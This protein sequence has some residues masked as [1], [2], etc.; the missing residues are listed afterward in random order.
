[1]TSLPSNAV[2]SAM[3]G[4]IQ[5]DPEA[6]VEERL[7]LAKTPLERAGT[8]YN[9]QVTMGEMS[10]RSHEIIW[11][12]Q[13][14]IEEEE[15]WKILGLSREQMWEDIRYEEVVGPAVNLHLQSTARKAKF[16][17]QIEKSWGP[18]WRSQFDPENCLLPSQQ[19]EHFVAALRR[20][21]MLPTASPEAA[22]VTLQAVI[23][24]R[25]AA[26]RP[27]TR[28]GASGTA[29]DLRTAYKELSSQLTV[30]EGKATAKRSIE[31]NSAPNKRIRIDVNG[32]EFSEDGLEDGDREVANREDA[33][34]EDAD[35]EDADREDDDKE[36]GDNENDQ[37][38]EAES[39]FEQ[40]IEELKDDLDKDG[41]RCTVSKNLKTKLFSGRGRLE[42]KEVISLIETMTPQV[43]SDLCWFHFRQICT[44]LG[45]KSKTGGKEQLSKRFEV[46][47]RHRFEL[48]NFMT[49][50]QHS[51]WF[52]K[53]HRGDIPS[54]YLGSLRYKPLPP[55]E[56]DYDACDVLERFA[57]AGAA[58]HWEKDGTMIVVGAMGYLWEDAD[59]V[60]LIKEEV[61]M[62]LHH[63][64]RVNGAGNLGWLRSAYHAQIQQIA[65]QDPL[66][67]AL[68]A[69][70]SPKK[71]WKQISFP[72]YM[73][74]V[75]PGDST[76]FQHLDLNLPRYV[77]CER[78]RNRIQTSLTLSPETEQNCTMVVPGFHN[79]IKDW[80]RDVEA[81]GQGLT[82]SGKPHKGNC[83]KTNEIYSKADEQK[84]GKLVP[85]VCGPGDIRVSRPEILHGSTAN[86][87][88]YAESQRW[89]VNPWFVGI[90]DDHETL[91]VPES[92]TWASIA[93]THRDLLA[94]NG[95]P[96]GQTNIHGRPMERFPASVA[97]RNISALSDA[98]IGLRR[99]DD[100]QV[101]ADRDILLGSDDRA[102]WRFVQDC[103]VRL[104]A[105][106]KENMV[107]VR[108][109]E[110]QA[111]GEHSFYNLV[112]S[113]KYKE[114]TYE[115]GE[116]DRMVEDTMD[117]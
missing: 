64:R 81:R 88:G 22:R 62:Y 105:A 97:L 16:Y 7:G 40:R 89:V 24:G 103:R 110:R 82:K 11:R 70:T 102:S 10:Q 58:D 87:D 95:T 69:A 19:S 37:D 28:A 51:G 109:L 36:D 29:G 91:D 48:G 25:M 96:S 66:Y 46:V 18:G 85:C 35:R 20:I 83:T 61:L 79:V 50:T 114:P 53:S 52:R 30:G 15:V 38:Y 60:K 13:K 31:Q 116:D 67:Y 45:I 106:Y 26:R 111:Y 100:P 112:D 57:G 39:G 41:C 84:Y 90:Q 108:Q 72:Y 32:N 27:G 71:T 23:D 113:G 14:K 77:E 68:V 6:W 3:T 33:D 47:R 76:Y 4:A 55:A 17:D 8:L 80:W 92:G 5:N 65:R 117:V 34:R 9:C 2:G 21:S 104:K 75:L 59:I 54:D 63:R 101:L 86:K 73:K 56:W 74:A 44:R 98:L 12:I 94:T 107:F 43:I 1:M 99:W 115:E 49:S 42:M 78:G 93:Q